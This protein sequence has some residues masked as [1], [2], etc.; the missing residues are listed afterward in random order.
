VTPREIIEGLRAL[1]LHRRYSIALEAGVIGKCCPDC[2]CYAGTCHPWSWKDTGQDCTCR[3]NPNRLV[4]VGC[5]KAL[6]DGDRTTTDRWGDHYHA[7][8]FQ[9]ANAQTV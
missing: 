9:T 2:G 8:C 4:C 1:P 7:G 6:V 3:D 5:D